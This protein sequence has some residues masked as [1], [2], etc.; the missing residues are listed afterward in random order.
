MGYCPYQCI[1]CKDVEDN[2]WTSE[3][4]YENNEY[5]EIK[6][7]KFEKR[8]GIKGYY[9]EEMGNDVCNKCYKLVRRDPFFDIKRTKTERT[10]FYQKRTQTERTLN[11][12]TKIIF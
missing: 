4:D 10:I 8:T 5:Q 12:Q 2:G 6:C 9:S 3:T 7:K 1:N 11:Y